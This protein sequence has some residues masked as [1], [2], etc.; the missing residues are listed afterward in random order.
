MMCIE[1]ELE[2]RNSIRVPPTPAFR[3]V[4][5]CILVSDKL[6]TLV[7]VCLS[8]QVWIYIHILDNGA[9]SAAVRNV[10]PAG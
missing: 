4:H 7:Y 6:Q 9:T 10:T 2:K 5:V 3:I 8:F 1:K